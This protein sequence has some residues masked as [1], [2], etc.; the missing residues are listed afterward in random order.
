[1]SVFSNLS[2]AA[3]AMGRGSREAL[4][5]LTPRVLT[6]DAIQELRR[7]TSKPAKPRIEAPDYHPTPTP[8]E[9]ASVELARL[10]A[11]ARLTN[12]VNVGDKTQMNAASQLYGMARDRATNLALTRRTSP[13]GI[14]AASEAGQMRFIDRMMDPSVPNPRWALEGFQQDSLTAGK[15]PNPALALDRLGS[16][17]PDPGQT[18]G[19]WVNPVMQRITERLT[20]RPPSP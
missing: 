2:A 14:R 1:M 4:P 7:L 18:V 20:K 8:P 17:A 6:R 16:E 12:A 10:R 19:R 13:L 3:K 11:A 15:P 5:A 9:I